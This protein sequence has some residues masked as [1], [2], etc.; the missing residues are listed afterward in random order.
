MLKC[1]FRKIKVGC[2]TDI[3]EAVRK[4]AT[5]NYCQLVGKQR[6]DAPV[7]SYDWTDYS[8]ECIIKSA[9]IGIMKI[10]DSYVVYL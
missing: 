10:L 7:P 1:Q 8:A 6:G 3:A 9:L 4:S 2:L 5:L